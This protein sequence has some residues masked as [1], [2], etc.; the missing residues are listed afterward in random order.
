MM[1]NPEF[2]IVLQK[3]RAFLITM[4]HCLCYERSFPATPGNCIHMTLTQGIILILKMRF[5]E[6]RKLL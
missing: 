3:D 4:H 6:D 5:K 1:K 2:A